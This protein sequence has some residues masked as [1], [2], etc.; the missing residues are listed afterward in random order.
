MSCCSNDKNIDVKD[1]LVTVEG[2][3]VII[4]SLKS[5]FAREEDLS[6]YAEKE[7]VN[8]LVESIVVDM[9]RHSD[10]G[11]EITL[12]AEWG[13][14]YVFSENLTKLNLTLAELESTDY[15]KI[16]EIEIDKVA[17]HEDSETGE[18]VMP[19]ILLPQDVTV[20]GKA[21]IN[22]EV[23]E[24]VITESKKGFA[25]S[26]PARIESESDETSLNIIEIPNKSKVESLDET[27]F[28]NEELV[29]I[30]GIPQ[31]V[32]DVNVFS[33]YNIA[34]TGWYIFARITGKYGLSVTENTTV[35]GAEGYIAEIGNNHIDIA[36]RF[37]ITGE[38]QTV[39]V[40]WGNYTD[41]F[42][43]KATDLALRNFDYMATFYVYDIADF[44]AWS[45][46]DATDSKFVSGKKYY[47]NLDGNYTLTEV[48]VGD[49]L[50][51]YYTK[52]ISYSP[53]T[54]T[55]ADGTTYYTEDEEGGYLESE[56]TV[57]DE[58]PADEYFTQTVTY[59]RTTDGAFVE[60]V[61]YYTKNGTEYTLAEVTVGDIASYYVHSKVRF[62]GM[63]RNVTYR[64]KELIDCPIE[65]VLPEIDDDGYGAWIEIQMRYDNTYSATLI[66]PSSDVKIATD[67]TV[68]Q[69]KGVN[70]IDLHYMDVY[71][72]KVWRMVNTHSNY[73]GA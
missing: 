68:K 27:K 22:G 4:D 39:N 46:K 21:P 38:S 31:Y 7:Y 3:K 33:E 37:G 50:P 18:M 64:C 34:R 6:T 13:H 71:D 65:I 52:N 55:F 57:G 15:A 14:K 60:G 8:T 51:V 49:T 28:V 35:T 10:D 53:A 25:D 24:L 54:G 42:V 63:V 19:S 61:D 36:V 1:K 29:D 70:V 44:T 12:T 11:E 41:T 69:T 48:T 30:V 16:I 5:E 67:N 58:I 40:N 45:F 56:V 23:W 32:S 62:E 26:Y 59:V 17:L 20:Y 66:P 2:M 9:P 47:V 43:F 72:S 73:A